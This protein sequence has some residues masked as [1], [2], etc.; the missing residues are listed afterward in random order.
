MFDAR[1]FFFASVFNVRTSNA[2]HARRFNF[3]AI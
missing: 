1:L 3:L 2:V